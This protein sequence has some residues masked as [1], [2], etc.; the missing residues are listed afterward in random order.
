[1]TPRRSLPFTDSDAPSAVRHVPSWLAPHSG[2]SLESS[3]RTRTSHTS[4]DFAKSVPSTTVTVPKESNE[5]I[6]N[7]RIV[8]MQE[9]A[10]LE[11]DT[12]RNKL[13]S[14][15]AELA[16]VAEELERQREANR[17]LIRALGRAREDLFTD[18]EGEL[19]RLAVAVAERVVGQELVTPV[20]IVT[21]WVREAIAMYGGGTGLTLVLSP[22]LVAAMPA[23]QWETVAGDVGVA[24]DPA[25]EGVCCELR[26]PDARAPLSA[27]HRLDAVAE[28][29]GVGGPP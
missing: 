23:H 10:A 12:I 27:K 7:A 24:V 13:E 28:A 4:H 29:L 16:A 1:M 22:D 2:A 5:S 20:P 18:G 8:A 9:L 14:A 17:A 11:V 6:A 25:L 21:R 15:E 3:L 19:L 26:G